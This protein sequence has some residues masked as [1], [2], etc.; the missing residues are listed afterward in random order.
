MKMKNKTKREYS[1][2]L[3]HR[4]KYIY[5]DKEGRKSDVFK[6]IRSVCMGDIH[7]TL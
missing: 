6:N 5:Q 4:D 1:Y 7:L 2:D 3:W